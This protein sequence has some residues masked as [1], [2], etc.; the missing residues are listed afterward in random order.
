[1]GK[2]REGKRVKGEGGAK[3][4]GMGETGEGKGRVEGEDGKGRD[5]GGGREGLRGNG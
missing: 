2:G 1:M 3:L 4:R 5:K